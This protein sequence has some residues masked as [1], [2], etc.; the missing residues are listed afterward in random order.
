MDGSTKPRVV[1]PRSFSLDPEDGEVILKVPAGDPIDRVDVFVPFELGQVIQVIPYVAGPPDEYYQINSIVT[2]ADDGFFAGG[3]DP[4]VLLQC[5]PVDY[6]TETDRE[7]EVIESFN[8]FVDLLIDVRDMLN[9]Y[10]N[11]DSSDD[12]G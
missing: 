1:Q 8:G 12:R 6:N 3:Q 4:I 5:L 9:G 2:N 10:R 11:N 7:T